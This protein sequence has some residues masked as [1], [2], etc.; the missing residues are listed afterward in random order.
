[1][2]VLFAWDFRIDVVCLTRLI[3]VSGRFDQG[4]YQ[5]AR[6]CISLVRCAI[7]ASMVDGTTSY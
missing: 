4:K 1:V 3:V 6:V 2:L 7:V 5:C